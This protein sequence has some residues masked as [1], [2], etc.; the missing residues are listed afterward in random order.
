MVGHGASNIMGSY[1]VLQV[2][3]IL[4][5]CDTSSKSVCR[6]TIKATEVSRLGD[7]NLL[8]DSGS[9]NHFLYDQ[10]VVLPHFFC[11]N[12]LP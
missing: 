4:N 12:P 11:I 8:I 5:V 2:W 7:H 3:G 6:I 10:L 9:V 1:M